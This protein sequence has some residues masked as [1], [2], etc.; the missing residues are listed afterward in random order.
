MGIPY[1]GPAPANAGDLT[2]KS[3]VDAGDT[4]IKTTTLGGLTFVKLTQAAYTALG[5]KDANTVYFI[6]G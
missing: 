4:S 6:V 1:V 2:P 3:Y 5:T